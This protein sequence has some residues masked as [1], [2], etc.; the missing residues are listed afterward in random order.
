MRRLTLRDLLLGVQIALCALLLTAS[1][2]ALRGMD[3]SLHAPIGFV[4]QGAMVAEPTCIWRATLTI[5]RF[6]GSAPHH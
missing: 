6:S 4:P 3:R 5:L 1:L 2:V